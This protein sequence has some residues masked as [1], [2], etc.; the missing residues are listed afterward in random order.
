VVLEGDLEEKIWP[1]SCRKINGIGPKT[2]Q[3]LTAAGLHTIGQLAACPPFELQQQ[4]GQN[5]GVWLHDVAWGRDE[6]PVVTQSE[7]VSIS[8]ETTF[9]RDLHARHDKAELGALFTKLCERLAADLLRKGYQGRTIGVKLRYDDFKSVTRDHTLTEATADAGLIRRT[10]GLCLRRVD[11][12]RRFRL[13]GVRVG[14]L[15]KMTTESQTQE[16]L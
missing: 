8:R 1:L 2:E 3:K 7:P 11:L 16:A 12:T 15:E 9:E 14:N 5:Q 6:R 13:L 10:A 4:F